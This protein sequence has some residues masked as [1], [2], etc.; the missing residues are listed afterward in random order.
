[1]YLLAQNLFS[2]CRIPGIFLELMNIWVQDSLAERRISGKNILKKAHGDKILEREMDELRRTP[3]PAKGYCRC[4]CSPVGYPS[5]E[6]YHIHFKTFRLNLLLL[7]APWSTCP[8]YYNLTGKHRLF[9][10]SIIYDFAGQQLSN[11]LYLNPIKRASVSR[12][13][14]HSFNDKKFVLPQ[15]LKVGHLNNLILQIVISF[16]IILCFPP[17]VKLTLN[18]KWT[19]KPKN[20]CAYYGKM[21]F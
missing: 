12:I 19:V 16:C 1:M 15:I 17:P 14:F 5:D 7:Y 3:D 6:A 8:S 10:D 20:N 18:V 4:T 9:T 13:L 11:S 21:P 2:I